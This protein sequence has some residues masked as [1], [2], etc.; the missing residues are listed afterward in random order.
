MK[1]ISKIYTIPKYTL[2]F[3]V[4]FGSMFSTKDGVSHILSLRSPLSL[5]LY[6]S[7]RGGASSEGKDKD[8]Q[9]TVW[10]EVIYLCGHEVQILNEILITKICFL[11]KNI[12]FSFMNPY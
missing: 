1:S 7:P 3:W 4:L 2:L 6:L 8:K 5:S 11:F 9:Y 12:I 10:Q